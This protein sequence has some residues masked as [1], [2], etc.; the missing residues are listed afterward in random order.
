MYSSWC[1]ELDISSQGDTKSVALVNL[2]SA[3][4]LSLKTPILHEKLLE[5]A[6]QFIDERI[7]NE[8][9]VVYFNLKIS[10]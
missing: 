9:D 7:S 2:K 1:P 4:E 5:R 10:E 3:I 8:V 6:D